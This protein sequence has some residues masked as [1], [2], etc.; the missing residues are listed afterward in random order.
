MN[1]YK[2]NAKEATDLLVK[3]IKK[4]FDENGQGCNAIIGLSGGKDSTIVAAAC[5]KALGKDRVYGFGLPDDGQG[6]NDA[7]KIAEFLG[8]TYKT[9]PIGQIADHVFCQIAGALPTPPTAQT[10][11]NIPPRVRMT[12]L[13]ALSQSLNGRVV[14]TCNESENYIGYFTKGGD[15]LSDFEPIAHLTVAELMLVGEELGIPSEWVYKKP[16][17]GLPESMPDDDKFAKMGFS[18]ALLDKYIRTGAS[19]VETADDAI[20]KMH[21]RNAFKMEPVKTINY[22]LPVTV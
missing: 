14:G 3:G 6:I 8:I 1:N 20:K 21:E 16:D 19:G 4:W 2:F 18:Y 5:V 7:D 9:V 10:I 17:D 15:G 12:T 22:N 13:Y 11:Q